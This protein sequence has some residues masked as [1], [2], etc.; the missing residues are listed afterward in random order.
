MHNLPLVT[1]TGTAGVTLVFF[2]GQWISAV[3]CF[4]RHRHREKLTVN[5][6]QSRM[7]CTFLG[8]LI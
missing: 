8:P 2:G 7:Y 3:V 6:N 5:S 1:L 4:F